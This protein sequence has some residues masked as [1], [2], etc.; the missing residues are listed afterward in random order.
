MVR[1]KVT[2]LSLTRSE[3]FRSLRNLRES[4]ESRCKSFL[5]G[6]LSALGKSSLNAE[7]AADSDEST[8]FGFA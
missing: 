8:Q 4:R 6:G 2:N 3:M 1:K 5:E 7:I